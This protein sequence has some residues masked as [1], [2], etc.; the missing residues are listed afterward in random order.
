MLAAAPA[1]AAPAAAATPAAPAAAVPPRPR[2]RPALPPARPL[3][4]APLDV[5]GFT[6]TM[7]IVGPLLK[8]FTEPPWI[9]WLGMLLLANAYYGLAPNKGIMPSPASWRAAGWR[10]SRSFW[11]TA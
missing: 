10:R 1:A 11:C 4:A 2:R 3:A 6:D 7:P 5:P 9:Y 8:K